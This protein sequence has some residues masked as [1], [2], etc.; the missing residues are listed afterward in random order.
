MCGRKL[1]PLSVLELSLFLFVLSCFLMVLHFVWQISVDTLLVGTQK[2]GVAL[3]LKGHKWLL[4]KWIE[5]CTDV[6]DMVM[7][8]RPAQTSTTNV[9][10][11]I[12]ESGHHGRQ[13]QSLTMRGCGLSYVCIQFS[14]LAFVSVHVWPVCRR[15]QNTVERAD[16]RKTAKTEKSRRKREME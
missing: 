1:I 9:L 11:S 2:L 10:R 15:K 12:K 3:Y 13:C 6:F 8:K 5:K 14:G 4:C 16:E 7:F